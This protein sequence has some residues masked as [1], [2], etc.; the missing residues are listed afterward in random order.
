M[1]IAWYAPV[2]SEMSLIEVLV[3]TLIQRP[4]P[5]VRTKASICRQASTAMKNCA[6][7]IRMRWSKK[8]GTD[9]VNPHDVLGGTDTFERL[10]AVYLERST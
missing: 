2:C 3:R 7:D 1:Y 10:S 4:M 9:F 8:R 5:A 6:I